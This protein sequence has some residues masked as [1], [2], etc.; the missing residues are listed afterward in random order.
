MR[1]DETIS[2]LWCVCGYGKTSATQAGLHNVQ[3][4]ISGSPWIF[5][6]NCHPSSWTANLHEFTQMLNSSFSGIN[7][8]FCLFSPHTENLRGPG[9]GFRWTAWCE[10]WTSRN[11][12]SSTVSWA[13]WWAG[14]LW[15]ID[16]RPVGLSCGIWGLSPDMSQRKVCFSKNRANNWIESGETLG[17]G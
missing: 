14:T 12:P 15:K 9:L 2:P 8:S 4:A 10:S 17:T 16:V 5:E 1:H 3:L 13:P 11:G 6:N 7:F